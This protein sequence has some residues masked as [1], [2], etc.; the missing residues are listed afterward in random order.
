MKYKIIFILFVL[1]FICNCA[2]NKKTITETDYLKNIEEKTK[3]ELPAELSLNDCIDLALKNNLAIRKSEM[4]K[5]IA[6]SDKNIA[7]SAF[8]P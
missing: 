4:Q 2:T 6:E 8:L 7:L 1:F 5:Q 3:N